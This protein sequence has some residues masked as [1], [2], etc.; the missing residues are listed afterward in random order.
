MPLYEYECSDPK[1]QKRF[2]IHHPMNG[3]PVSHY[4]LPNGVDYGGDLDGL[5][6]LYHLHHARRGSLISNRFKL[7]KII[8]APAVVT[9]V[10][11]NHDFSKREKERLKK[12]SNDHWNRVGRDEAIQRAE[13]K[14]LPVPTGGL[15][16]AVKKMRNQ[17]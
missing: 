11:G 6:G 10:R 16:K 1:C 9:I 13:A 7:Q 2:E 15:A 12:R 4:E 8:S 14:G 5:F 17:T 3:P